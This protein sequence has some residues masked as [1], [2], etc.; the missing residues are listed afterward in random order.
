MRTRE[1]EQYLGLVRYLSARQRAKLSALLHDA[2]ERDQ[3]VE[4]V[5]KAA[6]QRLNCPR[7]SSTAFHRHG[8]AHGLQRFRCNEC[9]RTFNSLTG[10]PLAWLHF[11]FKWLEYSDCL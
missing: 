9:G 4:L 7:C 11:K 6:A 3:A 8:H 2:D 5:E 10:T 1:F